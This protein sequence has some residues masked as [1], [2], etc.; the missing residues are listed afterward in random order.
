M[1]ETL[2]FRS[3]QHTIN[4]KTH[5]QLKNANSLASSYFWYDNC[6]VVVFDVYIVVSGGSETKIGTAVGAITREVA[7]EGY[8]EGVW[9]ATPQALNMTDALKIKARIGYWIIPNIW[10]YERTT[11]DFISLQLN[12]NQLSASTWTFRIYTKLAGI[13]F[14]VYHG[15]SNKE[16]KV[17]NI[18]LVREGGFAGAF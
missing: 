16:S 1:A 15:D 2:F 12:S 10:F 8:Q 14:Y 4:T 7:G 18:E 3:D 6:E 17:S 11:R 5:Y 13:A 9:V